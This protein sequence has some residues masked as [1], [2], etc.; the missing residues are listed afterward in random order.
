MG[1][2]SRR[3]LRPSV[4]SAVGIERPKR[5]LRLPAGLATSWLPYVLIL[6]TGAVLY[7]N[8]FS[9]PFLF[10]DHFEIVNN[11]EIRH[12]ESP[13]AYLTRPRGLTDFTLALN[14]HWGGLDVWGYHL[15]NVA[16]HVVNGWL[17][18]A[19]ALAI[20]RLP[21]FAGRYR[22]RAADLATLVALVFV[23]H[24]LQTM[25]ASYLVQRAESLSAMFYLA[26]VLLFT[27]AATVTGGGRRLLIYAAIVVTSFLGILSKETAA[28]VPFVLLLH[29]FCFGARSR[30]T[31]TKRLLTAV[32]FAAPIVYALYLV[33]FQLMPDSGIGGT[34]PRAW[35]FIPTAGFNV[36]GVTPWTYLLTQFGVVLRYL[37]LYFLPTGQCF[38]YAWP[39]VDTMWRLDVLGPFLIL[40]A[41]AVAGILA[42]RRYR[43]ATFCIG[44]LFLCLAPTSSILPL[45]DA[46]FEHRMYLPIFGLTLLVVVAGYDGGRWLARRWRV[47]AKR[48]T[49]GLAFLA[50]LWVAALGGL[51]MARNHVY[52]DPMRL[53]RDSISVSPQNWRAHYEYGDELARRGRVDEAISAL[54]ESIRLAPTKGTARIRLGGIYTEQRRLDEAKQV[55]EPATEVLQESVAAAA[56]RQLGFVYLLKGDRDSAGYEFSRAAELMPRWVSVHLQLARLYAQ[57]GLWF[58]AAGQWNQAI[59]LDPKLAARVGEKAAIANY[60]AGVIFFE[61]KKMRAALTMLHYAVRYEPDFAEARQYLA[62]CYAARE[63]WDRAQEEM[64]ELVRLNPDDS[65]ARE[66]LKRIEEKQQPLKP[67]W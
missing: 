63:Q 14:Y 30:S 45:R 56:H 27:R 15:V 49:A 33:R 54:R 35:F 62:V 9:I 57:Q 40:L 16:I 29:H 44:W 41:V 61:Q 48:V 34:A 2:A 25:A 38:D 7:A 22:Q 53:A 10:D 28:T 24:P 39:V 36:E 58:G 6:L 3:K 17:V 19:L 43:L 12:L 55:L 5:R 13:I 47:S 18:Y 64:E 37:R 59:Q 46:A 1:K 8:S 11:E 20:L 66:N 67:S 51:T 21:F 23:A 31:L 32:L 4:E 50:A 60:R 26:S 52:Q 42:Y 65:L